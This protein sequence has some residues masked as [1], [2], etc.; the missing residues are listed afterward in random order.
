MWNTMRLKIVL[1]MGVASCVLL[2]LR[3][4]YPGSLAFSSSAWQMRRKQPKGCSLPMF[5]GRDD[6]S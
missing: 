1:K 4:S 3:W 5:S 6:I 2:F